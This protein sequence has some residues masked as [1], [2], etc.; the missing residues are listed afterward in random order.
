MYAGFVGPYGFVVA[1]LRGRWFLV[2]RYLG[3]VILVIVVI[4]WPLQVPGPATGRS[5]GV[6]SMGDGCWQCIRL[7]LVVCIC[8]NYYAR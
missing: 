1:C 6:C 3:G 7:E 5:S 4:L 2:G 8:S